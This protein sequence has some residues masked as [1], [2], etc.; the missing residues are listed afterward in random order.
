METIRRIPVVEQVM[1]NLQQLIL[2]RGY[3][4][5]DKMPTEKEACEMFHVGR[6]TV[7]EAYRMMQIMGI[8]ESRQGSGS[9]VAN[10]MSKSMQESAISWFKENGAD[11]TDY[12]EVRLALE[13]METRLAAKRATDAEIERIAGIHRLFCQSVEENDAI[14]MSKYDEAFHLSI[15]EASH[16]WLFVKMEKILA[17][18]IAEY[19]VR[20][21]S[22]QDNVTHAVIPHQTILDALCLRDPEKGEAAVRQ[23]L[24]ISL[25]DMRQIIGSPRAEPGGAFPTK[26]GQIN[27]GTDQTD[28]PDR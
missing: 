21:F 19:R 5:G 8:L 23:H 11:I 15:A 6:S 26:G 27:D 16:N 17:D 3:Q 14:K 7:R 12:M 1:N 9:V 28:F 25:S 10:K 20:S 22:I 18:C 24:N 2:E 13:P 4:P